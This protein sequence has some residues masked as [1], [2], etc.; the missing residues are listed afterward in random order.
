VLGL[1]AER[2]LGQAVVTG[3]HGEHRLALPL[4]RLGSLL[5]VLLL[6]ALLVGNR[7]R[8]LLLGLDQLRLHVDEDLVEHL[9]RVFGLVDQ[10]VDVRADERAKS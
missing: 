2:R 5:L 6:D 3:A 7:D 1:A 9:L 4:G 8:D 10:L